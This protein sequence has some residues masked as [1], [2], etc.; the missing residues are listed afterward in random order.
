MAGS[1]SDAPLHFGLITRRFCTLRREKGPAALR[2]PARIDHSN[3]HTDH[4][5]VQVS[6]VVLLSIIVHL[7]VPGGVWSEAEPA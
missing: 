7:I 4:G 6:L 2:L 3:S 5:H 1:V